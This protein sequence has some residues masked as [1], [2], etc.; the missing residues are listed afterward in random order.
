MHHTKKLK[1]KNIEIEDIK[2]EDILEQVEVTI[3]K[4]A[5][6]KDSRTKR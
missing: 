2:E 1:G 3:A 5:F 6:K 4:D